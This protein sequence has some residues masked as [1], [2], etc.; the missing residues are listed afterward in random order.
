M[1]AWVEVLRLSDGGAAVVRMAAAAGDGWGDEGGESVVGDVD[2]GDGG[3]GGGGAA[4]VVGGDDDV[5]VMVATV[6]GGGGGNVM[7]MVDLVVFIGGDEA[8]TTSVDESDAKTSEY[9]SCESE[10]SVDTTTSMRAPVENAPKV[11]CELKVWIDAPII[12]EYESDS[13]DDSV[14]N[15][16]KDKEKPSF[17]FTDSVKHVKPSREN[18]K[19]TST[20]NHCPKVEKQGSNGHTRKGLGYAFTKK[21]CFVCGSFSHLIRYCDF[22]EKKMA[23]QAA[24]TKSKNKVTG[25]RENRPVWNNVQRVNHQNK[26]C[27]QVLTKTGKVPVNA[28]RQNYSRQ[29]ASTSTAR[30]FVNE[31]RPKRWNKAHL[32]DYQE[33]KGVSVAFG[34]SNG[35][36]TGKGKIK[37]G[38]LD[39][40]DVYYVE[41]LKHY[42]LFF[43]SQMCDKKHKVF[44]TDTDC[45]VLSPDFKLP[46]EN[47]VLLKIPRQHNMYGFNLK[48]I[49]PS[50]IKREYSNAKT[51]QQNR[52]DETKNMTLIEA[53]RTML[54]YLFLPT[55]FWAEAVNIACY[56]LNRVLVT[57]PQI[58]THYELLTGKQPIISYL[59]P[60][61]CHVTILNTIDQLGKFNGKSDSGFLV[62]YS[63]NSKVFRVYNLET[64]RVKEN[65]HVNFLE[66]RPNVAGKGHA[67]MFDLDYLTNSMIYEPVS[68]ENQANKSAG[69]KEANNSAGTQANDDQSANSE[70]IDLHEEYFVLPTWSA[71]STTEELE[72]LKRQEKEANVAARKE[73][74]HEN[75]DANTNLLNVVS[76]PFSTADP[77]RALNDGEPSY[78]DDPS[79]PHLEDIYASP[80]EG[81]FTDSSYDDEDLPFEKKAIE[82]KWVYMNKK[83]ERG[84]VVRKKA[85]LVA[86]GHRQEE[87]I[88]YG[89]V[90]TPVARIEAI[91]IFL[92][93]ASYMGFIIYQMDVKSAFLYGT[94]DE[95]VY[96]TQPPGFI[97]PKFPTKVYKVV[98]ARLGLHQ[99]PRVQVYVDG[100][101]FGS[102]KKS[103]CDEFE[104]LMKNM[105]Q[106]SSMGELTFFLGLQVKQKED[107]IFISQDK[108]VAKILKKFDFFSVKTASTPIETQKPLVKDAEAADVDVHLYRSM[109]G[110]LMYLTTSRP[111]IMFAVCACSRFQVS[112]FDLEAYSDSDYASANLDRKSTTGDY[113]FNIMNTKIYIDNE[114]TICIVKNPVFHSKTKHIEIRHHFIRDDYEKKLIQ[115]KIHTDDNVADLLT[116][117]FVVSSKKLASPKQTALGKDETNPLIVDSLLK[118][119]WLSMHH[120]IAMKH[121]LFQS[122]RLLLQALIDRKKVVVTEDVIRHDLRLDDADGVDAKRTAWN[123]FSCSMASAVICLATGRKFNFSQYIFDSMVRNVDSLS[124]FLMY[125]RF[126]QVIINAQVDDLSSPTNQYTSPALTQKVFANMR[127]VGKGFSGVETPLFATMLVQPQ[128]PATEEEDEA[129]EMPNAPT[130]PSPTTEPSPPPQ[131][132]I[133]SPSQAQPATSSS[134]PQAQPQPDTFESSMSILNTLMEIC[135]TLRK[136]DNN[137]AIKDES[138]A[139]PTVFDDEEVTITMAQTLIKMKAEKARLLDEQ[140][141]K[142][143]NVKKHLD[144]IRK[145]QSLKRKP[146]SIAQA[147]KN[148]IVYLKNMAGYKMKHFKGMTYDKVRPIFEREYNKVQTLFKH[149]KDVDEEPTKKRV[150]EETPLQESFKKL[151]AVEVSCSHS[152]QDI[153]TDDP[154]EMSEEDVTNM[155]EIIP[156]SEFKVEALQ[157][158]EDLNVLWRLVKEKFSSAVPAVGKEKALWVELNRLFEPDRSSD[159]DLHEGQST[160]DQKF[161]YILQV[162]KKLGVKKLEGLLG[163]RVTPYA[164]T[165]H[166]DNGCGTTPKSTG[167][168][169]PPACS[170]STILSSSTTS[171]SLFRTPY[172]QKPKEANGSDTT[173][174]STG[175]TFPPPCSKSAI[176]CSSTTSPGI[177]GTPSGQTPQANIG[178]DTTRK[179]TCFPFPPVCS[180]SAILCSSTSSP[181][182]FGTAYAQKPKEDNCSGTTPKSTGFTSLPLCSKS[183]NQCPSS[184]SPS[185][186]GIPYAHTPQADSDTGA[187]T[188]GNQLGERGGPKH[189]NMQSAS[190]TFT[191]AINHT[192]ANP[193]SSFTSTEPRATNISISQT[194]SVSAGSRVTPYAQT[195]HAENGNDT[196]K[197]TGFTPLPASSKLVNLCSSSTSTSLFCTPD[198][199]T[200]QADTSSGTKPAGIQLGER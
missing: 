190:F 96:V 143:A 157:V 97:D 184:T 94:I 137:A 87:G 163:S 164:Q 33:F 91:R 180:K 135:A 44:F 110:S 199:Q 3:V 26:F 106:M 72:K 109:I 114:S 140:M 175:F 131:E 77:S 14:S 99:A 195:P 51:Q 115:L 153:P 136:D 90:F 57:K 101:I 15:V 41:E 159:E 47:Q 38:R 40:E 5:V 132:P 124:K 183:V 61:G 9:T 173:P 45:L 81:I 174:K 88:E 71:Y 134:P 117:A 60:F 165:P 83:D 120:V 16:Q 32:V 123:E 191:P 156:V 127:R 122:K 181:S 13:D 43:V 11:V 98:K 198:P 102:T 188:M 125:P 67:W 121:W 24:L 75:Q 66:N 118:T 84:V 92:A 53:A 49:D 17:A 200:P 166:A 35:R 1:V 182:M 194:P 34:G 176:F 113:G 93:F 55:K 130:P 100:I 12:E 4:E 148:M 147:R 116:K 168:T 170:K 89:E 21:A 141:A 48:N 192:H 95:E 52:V 146:I 19:E 187:K 58:K 171:S 133:H 69:S 29:A 76:T 150:A 162:I 160:K 126:L 108:Y 186:F 189:S 155:L 25:Q 6:E 193:V 37:A 107:G 178:S 144:N 10:S 74:T 7:M 59:R 196:T 197:S 36:I 128:P 86:Q 23:K 154:K 56:V 62:R 73:T 152:T 177:F 27:P 138:V 119:V 65:L 139:E 46:G 8:A 2:G 50:G 158:K 111:D 161:G 169:F 20:P 28:A 54:A 145:Y 172:A 82:T 142:R 68:V 112:S 30:P 167:F 185:L 103:W 70:E 42:N 79:M 104:E 31:T 22:H 63:L 39:F 85:R 149:D 179:S 18:V 80:S 129:E 105:F 151:K 78:P 64:K